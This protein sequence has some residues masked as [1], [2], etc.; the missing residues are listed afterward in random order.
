MLLL[1]AIFLS[2]I[3][4]EGDSTSSASVAELIDGVQFRNFDT[5]RS[6]QTF[7]IN[8]ISSIYNEGYSY[9]GQGNSVFHFAN[10][11]PY[12]FE[13][14]G[15]NVNASTVKVNT[16]FQGDDY[17]HLPKSSTMLNYTEC[18]ARC[19][20]DEK[21]RAWVFDGA[22]RSTSGCWLKSAVPSRVPKQGDISGCKKGVV[23]E[24]CGNAILAPPPSG[25]RSSV[26]LG[27]L[28]GGNIELRADGRLADWSIFNNEP[29]EINGAKKDVDEATFGVLTSQNGIVDAVL[30]R[31]RPPGTGFPS[32]QSLSYE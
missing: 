18:E 5:V 3:I 12:L 10:G 9:M 14:K 7:T 25:M 20:G 26:P 2:T 24:N 8:T 22:E 15:S 29:E 4:G 13:V 19:N 27:S 6:E 17:L 23:D 31:T 28:G 30:L 21:C 11:L 16:D 32:V 1:L